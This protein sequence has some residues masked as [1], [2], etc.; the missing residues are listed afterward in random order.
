MVIMT[1][2]FSM[3]TISSSSVNDTETSEEKSDN[4]RIFQPV[5]WL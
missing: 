1:H 4:G 3:E 2:I 5:I